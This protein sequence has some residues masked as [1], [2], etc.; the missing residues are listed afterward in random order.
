MRE[1][2]IKSRGK[3]VNVTLAPTFLY[4]MENL[5]GQGPL[6]RLFEYSGF[7]VSLNVFRPGDMGGTEPD[8]VV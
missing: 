5:L 8:V 3:Q 1:L 6:S 4:G 7:L 2:K